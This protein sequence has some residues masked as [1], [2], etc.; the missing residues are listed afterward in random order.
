[1]FL[2]VEQPVYI[3]KN[4]YLNGAIPFDREEE[5]LVEEGFNP[6]FTIIE[7]GDEVYLSCELPETFEGFLG[8]IHST[9]TLTRV[10]L[11]D[12]DFE[13]PDG[14]AV[15]I[16]LDYTGKERSEKSVAGP[17]AELK[18]GKNRIKVWG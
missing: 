4:V 18:K 8:E 6:G 12:A 13:N 5:N 10:R 7:E 17:I 14:S 3:N 15:V 11:A 2:Q 16:D 1:M 9:E